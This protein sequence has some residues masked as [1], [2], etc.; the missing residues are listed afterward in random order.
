ML[1]VC[2]YPEPRRIGGPRTHN[3]CA[4]SGLL[5]CVS[6]NLRGV[7]LRAKA[8]RVCLGVARSGRANTLGD[9][10]LKIVLGTPTATPLVADGRI[11]RDCADRRAG[12][13]ARFWLAPTTFSSRASWCESARIVEARREHGQHA[14]LVG[15]RGPTNMA[16]HNTVPW[17]AEDL[18]GFRVWFRR[19]YQS[20]ER[21]N[22]AWGSAFWSM[23]VPTFEEVALP[24]L[25]VTEPNP[26]TRLDYWRFQSQQ[27]AAYDRMHGADY[28][29]P[30]ARGGGSP[31]ISW[32][33][34]TNSIIGWSETI[35]ISLRGILSDRLGERFPFGDAERERWQDLA[36][37]YR[38]VSP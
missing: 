38:A 32:A 21:L 17:G 7:P 29:P 10:G 1:G 6:A 27:V 25:T 24:N 13:A 30:F 22:E 11:S 4:N 16:A 28:P 5:T 26:A 23:E 19:N 35:S 18:N 2:Y 12:A 14:A 20:P 3:A 33:S 34:S 37:R 8:R 15:W 9:A 31:T 36:S